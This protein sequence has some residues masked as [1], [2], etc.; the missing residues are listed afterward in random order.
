M[1][2]SADGEKMDDGDLVEQPGT[3]WSP[4][5]LPS[6]AVGL[7]RILGA[8]LW[9]GCTS[10]GG[11]SAGWLYREMVLKRRW[12]DDRTFLAAMALAQVMPGANGVKLSVLI[13]Q[14]LR[15]GAG[16]AVAAFGLLA[17]P[18]AVLL[19]VGGLF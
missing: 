11:G 18:F 5:V 6:Q 4:V 16:S 2:A 8:F 9:L 12:I 17:R 3:A 15:G 10:F 13:G 1:E 19:V 14:Q 7:W